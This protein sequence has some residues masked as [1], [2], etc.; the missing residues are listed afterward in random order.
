MQKGEKSNL[1]LFFNKKLKMILLFS[2]CLLKGCFIY[3]FFAIRDP[4]LS[5]NFVC[6][7]D[8]DPKFID[9]S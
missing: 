5:V 3:L 1:L 2:L 9:H 4:R 8:R 6:C 7:F